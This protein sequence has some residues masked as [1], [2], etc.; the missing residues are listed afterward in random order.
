[1]SA[2]PARPPSTEHPVGRMLNPGRSLVAV[3][4]TVLGY[5]MARSYLAQVRDVCKDGP[6][7]L[8]WG[9]G[10]TLLLY[11]RILWS[12]RSDASRVPLLTAAGTAFVGAFFG[13]LT[14]VECLS[15]RDLPGALA[16]ALFAVVQVM[17]LVRVSRMYKKGEERRPGALWPAVLHFTVLFMAWS[18]FIFG[19]Q[20]I[21]RESAH[22]HRAEEASAIGS[23]RTINS[24]EGT[25]AS[26][27]NRG[28]TASLQ[29]LDGSE[30]PWTA[31]SAGLID[32]VLASGEKS[33]FHFS[34][35]PGPRD[36]AGKIKS[37]SV[38]A[39][40]SCYGTRS[41]FTDQ[42]GAIRWTFESRPANSHDQVLQQR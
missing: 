24:A 32:S 22:G 27:F 5:G 21:D 23:L 35:E 25:Y 33:M 1:L 14:I 30:A 28:F 31:R 17:L 15:L 40:S 10:L 26:E 19:G 11:G 36:E 16:A 7:V 41:F 37:Y 18:V 9:L 34:Y 3:S 6:G 8:L 42:S 29:D 38:I 2:T 39:R 13:S 4:I 20:M 12:L